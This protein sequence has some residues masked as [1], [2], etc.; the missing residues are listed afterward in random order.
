MADITPIHKKD[1]T[2]LKENYRPVSILPSI[3]K[4]FERDMYEQIPLYFENLLSPFLCGF[5]KGFST[6]HCLIVMLERRKKGLDSGK[7]A[8]ALL[9]DLSKAFNCLHHEL[10]IAKLQAY[11]FDD[12]ALSYVY[13]YLSDRKQRTKIN[14]AFSVWCDIMSG[15]PQGSILGPLLFNI[16]LND[17]FYFTTGTEITNY[18]DNTTPYTIKVDI[19]SLIETLQNDIS[20]IIKWFQDNYFKLNTD[21]C[22]F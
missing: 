16:Y 13:S 9:T 11:G 5:R 14:G 20:I 2:T 1:E 18:A 21:K 7:V 6:Q 22:H 12:R 8:G 19:E 15:V 17:I 3:S 4:I 10:L